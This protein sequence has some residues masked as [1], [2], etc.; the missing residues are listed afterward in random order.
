LVIGREVRDV[1]C[2]AGIVFTVLMLGAALGIAIFFDDGSP[3]PRAR[4]CRRS[5]E[6]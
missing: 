3:P 1:G 2:A 6:R 5:L 4:E